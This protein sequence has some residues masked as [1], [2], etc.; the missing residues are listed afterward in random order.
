MPNTK[1]AIRRVKRAKLQTSVNKIRKSK[2]KSAVKQMSILLE[3]GKINEAKKFLPKFHSR[4][5]KI[6]KTGVISKKTASRKISR[7]TKRITNP[8]KNKTSL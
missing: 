7:V 6:V 8:K 3:S 2:Y 1:S 4:L 5:M